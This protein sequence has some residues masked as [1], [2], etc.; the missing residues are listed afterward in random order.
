MLR[1]GLASAEAAA[2]LRALKIRTSATANHFSLTH[3]NENWAPKLKEM[4][5]VI[6]FGLAR[7]I[8]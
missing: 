6:M 5:G 7:S 3:L 1:T 4:A 8:G 2:T